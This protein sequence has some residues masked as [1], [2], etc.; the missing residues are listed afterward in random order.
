[1]PIHSIHMKKGNNARLQNLAVCPCLVYFN[2]FNNWTNNLLCT[3]CRKLQTHVLIR[4]HLFNGHWNAIRKV[5]LWFSKLNTPFFHARLTI[6]WLTKHFGT[7]N[8]TCC[9]CSTSQESFSFQFV[10]I[11]NQKHWKFLCF[12]VRNYLLPIISLNNNFK[13]TKSEN[14]T[15]LSW[16]GFL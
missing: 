13:S 11:L 2:A 8:W 10:P 16:F 15:P 3:I 7:G 9:K 1:M 12:S 6:I 4:F 5:D 14:Y